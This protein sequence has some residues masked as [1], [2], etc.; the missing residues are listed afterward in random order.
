MDIEAFRKSPMGELRPISGHDAYLGQDYKHFA[1]M[2]Y[3]LPPSIP[4]SERTYSRVAEASMAVGRLDFA[5]QRLPNPSLLVRPA[6][7]REAQSTSALEG[8]YAPLD[9]VLE[10]DYLDEAQQSAELREV[11]N[12]VRAAERGL[13]LIN[14][15][16]ICLSLIAELQE[17]LVRGTRGGGY[18][19]GRL[20]ERHVYIGERHLGIELS[21][22]VPPLWGEDLIQRVSDWE[23]WINAEDD[24]PI[25]VKVAVGHYQF[26]TLHPFSDGNGRMGRLVV[27]LQLVEAKSLSYPVLNLSPWLKERENQYKDEMLQVSITG[28]FNSWVTF[29]CDGILAQANNAVKKIEDL[30]A[31]RA[32]MMETLR[33]KKVR[34]VVLDIA[35]S[36]IGYPY[37]TV[38]R[39]AELHKVTYPPANSAIGKLVE[40]GIL[41]EV[42]GERYGRMFVAP[43]I[44]AILTSR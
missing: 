4:L 9:E 28:D 32:E 34:G 16:P 2:P 26:E 22:F 3:P 37:I 18:D 11:M 6:L 12:Y 10:A 31:A 15:K 5:V 29:F 14:K 42:T 36:L 21:R 1:F 40:M 35:D 23:K 20:R 44:R 39:A 25:L 13:R 38:S 30:L 8:T 24:I 19:A 43:K 27:T 41:Q 7:R 17:I 33:K